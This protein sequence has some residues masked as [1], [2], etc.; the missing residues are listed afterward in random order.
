MIDHPSSSADP[1]HVIL[2]SRDRRFLKV[3]SFLLAREGAVVSTVRSIGDLP[4]V[5][6]DGDADLLILDMGDSLGEVHGV[7]GRLA[8][9]QPGLVVVVVSEG[10]TA[11]P[12]KLE[13][14]L[15]PKWHAL[16]GLFSLAGPRDPAPV[17]RGR[18]LVSSFPEG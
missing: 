3:A 14:T 5:V 10:D 9:T 13:L 6:R 7:I 15:W 17:E 2:A 16:G 1:P 4:E 8:E 11:F 12:Q 18:Q